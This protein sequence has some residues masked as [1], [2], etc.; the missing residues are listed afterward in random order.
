MILAN[1]KIAI[2]DS[3]ILAQFE[4]FKQ[5]KQFKQQHKQFILGVN[6]K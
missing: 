3:Q 4:L 5:L 6:R 2:F 1:R